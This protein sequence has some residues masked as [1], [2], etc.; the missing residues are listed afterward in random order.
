MGQRTHFDSDAR[1]CVQLHMHITSN[2]DLLFVD[3]VA[4]WINDWQ[5]S[6]QSV[7]MFQFIEMRSTLKLFV[8]HKYRRDVDKHSD[9]CTTHNNNLSSLT[10]KLMCRMGND[11]VTQCMCY[12]MKL[13]RKL[14][15]W[16]WTNGPKKLNTTISQECHTH[17]QR[18]SQAG[19]SRSTVSCDWNP[20]VSL[21]VSSTQW[22][23]HIWCCKGRALTAPL[24][25]DDVVSERKW[26]EGGEYRRADDEI[27]ILYSFC[28]CQHRRRWCCCW[29]SLCL[30]IRMQR[31]VAQL[32]R[33]NVVQKDQYKLTIFVFISDAFSCG[34]SGHWTD[35]DNGHWTQTSNGASTHFNCKWNSILCTATARAQIYRR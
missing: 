4:H 15:H 13:N 17:T 28:C 27:S 23:T 21:T 5:Q 19:H 7:E 26:E 1:C 24:G 3:R 33:Y 16:Q 20:F 10:L 22:A 11:R 8:E 29:R 9:E 2:M 35:I 30:E 34:A 18:T 25:S 14:T 6:C 12:F 31:P 32:E